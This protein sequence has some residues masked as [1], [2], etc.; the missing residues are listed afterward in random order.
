MT[1]R[2]E[3]AIAAMREVLRSHTHSYGTVDVVD[4]ARQAFLMA[5]AM[6]AASG[7]GETPAYGAAPSRTAKAA[8][9]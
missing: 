9:P 5:D 7:E 6:V 4:V 2:Q 8:Q 1:F 3:C